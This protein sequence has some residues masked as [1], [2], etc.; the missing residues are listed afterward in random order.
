MMYDTGLI[1]E[2]GGMR[3]TYTTGVLDFFMDNDIYLRHI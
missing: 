2:G 1:L 3:G